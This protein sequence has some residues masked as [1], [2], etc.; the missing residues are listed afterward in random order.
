MLTHVDETYV[1]IIEDICQG[2]LCQ[3]IAKE[4]G[5]FAPI[6]WD[7]GHLTEAGSTFIA[8]SANTKIQRAITYKN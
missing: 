4:G 1:S 3:A 7:Y 2:T 6:A 5:Q 8:T